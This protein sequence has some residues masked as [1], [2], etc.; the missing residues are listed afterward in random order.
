MPEL[1]VPKDQ[2]ICAELQLKF[3]NI[4]F[5]AGPSLPV[6]KR[7]GRASCDR[8]TGR[9]N[10]VP[11]RCAACWAHRPRRALQ[12]RTAW[13]NARGRRH[14][15]SAS[16]VRTPFVTTT[17][18]GP[19]SSPRRPLVACWETTAVTSAIDPLLAAGM[20]LPNL[21]HNSAVSSASSLHT[22]PRQIDMGLSVAVSALP[23]ARTQIC[24]PY[25][26]GR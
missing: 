4:C 16:A 24:A 10:R 11:F 17:P 20:V 18:C 8:G 26:A 13:I 23:Q 2:N 5:C 25:S 3:Q 19:C 21:Q 6:P 15:T 14:R 9:A 7:A 22:S 1:Q 12:Q